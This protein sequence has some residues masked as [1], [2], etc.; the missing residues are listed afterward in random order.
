MSL[1]R[2][3][4]HK[5]SCFLM[6]VLTEEGRPTEPIAM[7]S[8]QVGPG[9]ANFGFVLFLVGASFFRV[10]SFVCWSVFVLEGDESSG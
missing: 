10:L 7:T 1:T 5:T 6:L 8:A 2:V 3:R 4:P 9:K